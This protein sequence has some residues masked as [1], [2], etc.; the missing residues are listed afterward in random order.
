MSE[1]DE[2]LRISYQGQKV[3]VKR[4]MG[5]ARWTWQDPFG[6]KYEY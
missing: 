6:L 3:E 2:D 5:M 4:V 1:G